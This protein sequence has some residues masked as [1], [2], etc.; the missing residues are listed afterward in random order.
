[1]ASADVSAGADLMVIFSFRGIFMRSLQ[2]EP[3]DVS[4]ADDLDGDA[5]ER[6]DGG[7]ACVVGFQRTGHEGPAHFGPVPSGRNTQSLCFFLIDFSR[8]PAIH[9]ASSVVAPRRGM[10]R[11]G[12]A[13]L[14]PRR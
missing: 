11:R 2:Y 8:R 7:Q 9:V 5:G 12:E 1:A 14:R 10:L 6:A 13:L 4:V 3:L